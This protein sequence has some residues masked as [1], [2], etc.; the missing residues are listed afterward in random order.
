MK[1]GVLEIH[2][3][4]DDELLHLGTLCRRHPTLLEMLGSQPGVH[5]GHDRANPLGAAPSSRVR[6]WWWSLDG[7]DLLLSGLRASRADI[8]IVDH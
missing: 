5:S 4:S 2:S 8:S 7:L 3:L 1:T 6:V